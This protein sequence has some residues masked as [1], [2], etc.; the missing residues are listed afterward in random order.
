M[1]LREPLIANPGFH[2][3][4]TAKS[5]LRHT[6]ELIAVVLC[7][8]APAAAQELP[9]APAEGALDRLL[10]YVKIDTQSEEGQATVPST[11][12]QFDL[13]NLLAS[14]LK[15][16]GA[17]DVRVS[18]Y[19][20]VYASVPGNLPA[21]RPVPVVG[22]IA[23]MDTAPAASGTNVHPIVH[24]DYDGTDIVLPADPSQVL[25]PAQSPQL[26]SM[27]GDDIITA[28]G[29]TL[30]GSDDKAGC[31]EIMT[32]LDTLQHNPDIQHGPLAIAFTPD[33]EVGNGITQ[34]DVKAFGAQV[35][36]TVD[37]GDLGVINDE[38]FNME[39]VLIR[40]QGKMLG[41]MEKGKVI[42]SLFALADFV[43]RIPPALRAENTTGRHGYLNPYDASQPTFADSQVRVMLRDFDVKGLAD[44]EALLHRLLQKTEAK[45]PD[46]PAT[47]EAGPV[48]FNMKQVLDRFPEVT[49]N[50]VEAT[51]RAGI[52]PRL[53]AVRG[54]TDGAALAVLG[55]PTPNLFTGGSNF[56][57]P[58]EFNSRR[59]MEKTV[60][61]LVNLV[62]IYAEKATA[63]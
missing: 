42:N 10:R 58:L 46:V 62:Q 7:T 2:V 33:E 27:I 28:D 20:I 55:L 24:T 50:A 5:L 29:T 8:S 49:R 63:P 19:A 12:R 36:Y 22:F 44:K 47:F 35:A 32:L 60:E 23:H 52:T 40:F 54:G 13:A 41:G 3:T 30:L 25:R 21:S 1:P 51:R 15:T 34:F 11:A 45:F 56:H 53:R 16:L 39:N 38:N 9:N 37:G 48:H 57:G 14:E 18:D 17:Q 31:A 26:K 43:S 6:A 61:T 59:G 4:K